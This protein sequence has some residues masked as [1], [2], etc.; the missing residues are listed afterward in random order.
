MYPAFSVNHAIQKSLGLMEINTV[1]LIKI[2]VKIVLY[3][4]H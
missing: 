3:K 1:Y 2:L 4:K